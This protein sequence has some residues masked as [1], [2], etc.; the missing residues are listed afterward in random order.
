RLAREYDAAGSRQNAADHRL[1]RL[2]LPAD[3]TGVVVDGGYVTGLLFARDD[4]ERAAEPE[5]T[6]RVGRALHMISH[7]LM[8]VDGVGK[9]ETRIDGHGRPFDA[10]IGPRQPARALRGAQHPHVLLGDHRIG[11]ADQAA[12]LA[13]VHVHMPGLARMDHARDGF[14]AL[15]PDIDQYGRADRV[16][17]PHVM[18]NVLEVTD[19]FAG[20][21]VK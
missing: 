18:G 10:A 14:A 11:E 17:I 3:L 19:V 7:R 6:A 15:V 21:E 1:R 13:V 9:P 8:Q 5:L 16:E 12:I 4:L 2:D 20:V